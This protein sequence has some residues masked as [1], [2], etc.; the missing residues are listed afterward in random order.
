MISMK[1]ICAR[2]SKSIAGHGPHV[3]R[4][5][6]PDQLLMHPDRHSSLQEFLIFIVLHLFRLRLS[7]QNTF[8]TVSYSHRD[9]HDAMLVSMRTMQLSIFQAIGLEDIRIASVGL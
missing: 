6:H 4:E 7:F 1:S 3:I 8:S 2:N 9:R 5:I